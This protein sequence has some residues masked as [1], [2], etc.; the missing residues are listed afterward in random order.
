MLRKLLLLLAFIGLTGCVSMADQLQGSIK[1]PSGYGYAIVSLTGKAF[2]PDSASANLNWRSLDTLQAGTVWASMNTDTI[3]GGPQAGM[4]AGKLALLTLPPG[5]YVLET[6]YASW[7]EETAW[8]SYRKLHTYPL[9]LTFNL[10][11]GEAVYLGEVQLDMS[12]LPSASLVDSH[13]RD[14]N[15]M[16]RIWKIQDMSPVVIRLLKLQPS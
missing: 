7:R 16:Q 8:G 15:H 2:N 3:F 5:R 13:V 11:E 4:A 6:A 12:Y 10:N 9:N 14:F 1:P